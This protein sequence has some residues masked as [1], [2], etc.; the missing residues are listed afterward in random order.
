M[1]RFE[2]YLAVDSHHGIYGPQT[3]AAR[4][5]RENI[6]V[7][8][9]QTLLDGPDSDNYWEVWEDVVLSWNK[10]GLSILESDGDIWLIDTDTPLE[11]WEYL[12]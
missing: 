8:D 10:E 7:D 1:E 3:F 5:N 9:W 12:L 11:E 2:P 6:S 4:F